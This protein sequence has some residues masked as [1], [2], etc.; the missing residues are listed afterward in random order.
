[1]FKELA[2]QYDND[3]V[4]FET[5]KPIQIKCLVLNKME[6]FSGY[7]PL[8]VGALQVIYISCQPVY[9]VSPHSSSAKQNAAYYPFS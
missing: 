1:M 8:R 7:L 2:Y 5:F 9:F 3:W 6:R 4:P